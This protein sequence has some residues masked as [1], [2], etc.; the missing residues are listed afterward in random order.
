M[1]DRQQDL[2][3]VPDQSPVRLSLTDTAN[4]DFSVSVSIVGGLDKSPFK[5]HTSLKISRRLARAGRPTIASPDY[6]LGIARQREPWSRNDVY[7]GVALLQAE[8]GET[9]AALLTAELTYGFSWFYTDLA[10]IVARHGDDPQPIFDRVH[11]RL[12]VDS[13]STGE[14]RGAGHALEVQRE[15]GLPAPK[16]LI[17]RF[18]VRD[19]NRDNYSNSYNLELAEAYAR[20]GYPADA[21]DVWQLIRDKGYD[22]GAEVLSVIAISQ[23]RNGIDPRETVASAIQLA[24][25]L[26]GDGSVGPGWKQGEIYANL[27]RAYALYDLDPQPLIDRALEKA[28]SE[29]S[30]LKINTYI[31]IAKAQVSFGGDGKPAITLALHWADDILKPGEKDGG[32]GEPIQQ[33]YW[34]DIFHTQ[35]EAGHFDEARETLRRLDRYSELD[36]LAY[37]AELLAE[38]A[39]AQILNSLIAA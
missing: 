17:D 15:L 14:V 1:V 3:K 28:S 31:E 35:L 27:G 37:K 32:Y 12:R 23:G 20:A 29:P 19:G 22:Q 18:R 30:N 36:I 10:R 13:S 39:S 5:E 34:E 24:E 4:R 2:G 16:L 21:L 25:A 6:Y 33:L 26:K 11:S 8:M 7:E 9:S 38:L